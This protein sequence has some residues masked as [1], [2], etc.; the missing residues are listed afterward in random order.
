MTENHYAI[1]EHQALTQA[2]MD[3]WASSTITRLP[4]MQHKAFQHLQH[5]GPWLV[6]FET[7]A[8]AQLAEL[9]V[10]LGKSAI[11]GS[12]SSYLQADELCRHLGQ[13]L[14]AMAPDGRTV[15]LRSYTASVMPVL[16]E[17]RDREWHAWLFGPINDWW[18]ESEGQLTHCQGGR[19][20]VLP[21]HQPISLD[22]ALLQRL[23]VD[24]Q[25]L[26]L[27]EELENCA[28][29]VFTSV[30]HGARLDQVNQALER[31]RQSGLEHPDDQLLFATLTLMERTPLDETAQWQQAL[32][33]VIE[34]GLTLSEALEINMDDELS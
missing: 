20:H 14:L 30:C 16:H 23:S 29:D 27:L 10:A 8:N 5:E 2:A 19:L 12:L 22:A 33:G 7:D 6:N 21:D 17:R 31:A 3:Y 9:Q 32:K 15:L 4:I 24:P 34:N 1:V 13:A 25:S 26:A 28:P 11:L 18:V